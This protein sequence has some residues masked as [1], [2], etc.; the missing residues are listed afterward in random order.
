MN[1]NYCGMQDCPDRSD[2]TTAVCGEECNLSEGGDNKESGF[3]CKNGQC[4][5]QV[6]RCDSF[7]EDDCGDGSDE[8]IYDCV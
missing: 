4:V 5:A 2:E 3:A 8:E 1:K 6:N 7:R